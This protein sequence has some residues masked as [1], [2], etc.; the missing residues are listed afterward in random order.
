M[1]TRAVSPV[2][3][4]A[5]CL[6]DGRP[7]PRPVYNARVP[8]AVTT[9]PR[10]IAPPVTTDSA[11]ACKTCG[12][13]HAVVRL[14]YGERAICIRCGATLTR[15]TPDSLSRTAAFTVAA[16][17]VYVPAYWFPI[18]HLTLYAEE[19]DTTVWA[20]MLLFYRDGEYAMAVVVLLASIV[21]PAVK[22]IALLVLVITT[23]F[24]WHGGRRFRT[25]LFRFIELVGR[26][27]MLDVFALSIW[28]ATVKLQKLATISPGPG[29]LP[30][31]SLVVLT[32]LATINFDPQTIW[33]SDE[34]SA[35]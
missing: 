11:V 27:A 19:S 1:L 20:G 15:R 7:V 8:P 23:R 30:F 24:D 21:I 29:L 6:P 12:E 9:Q 18:L 26:W 33:D 13:V 25:H 3:A 16:L 5:T 14:K 10:P 2:A 35:S 28:V 32:M 4:A 31:G 17:L 22:L 34:G